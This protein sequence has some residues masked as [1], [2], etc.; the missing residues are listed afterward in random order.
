M[1]DTRGR[2]LAGHDGVFAFT[3][4][5]RRGLGVALGTPAYVVDIEP[6]TNRV[7]VGSHELLAR[8]GLVA[9]RV[10]WVA[11][12]PPSAGV[13]EAEVR[14]RYRSEA[15]PAVVEPLED[16]SVRVEFRSYRNTRWRPGRAPSSTAAMRCW[17][18]AASSMPSADPGLRRSRGSASA[19][20]SIITS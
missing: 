11:G 17:A 6:A 12:D 7:V 13:F 5:Q 15:A 2:V 4:G 9:D 8:R 10:S 3:V 20:P 14:I 16:G 1:V 18:A 19:G